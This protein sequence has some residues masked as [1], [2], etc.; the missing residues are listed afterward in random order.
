MEAARSRWLVLLAVAIASM[1]AVEAYDASY[2]KVRTRR[3]VIGLGNMIGSVTGKNIF[4]VFTNY[5]GYGCYCGIGGRGEPLDEV[6]RCCQRHDRCFAV[7]QKGVCSNSGKTVYS[8][9]YKYTAK[10][11]KDEHLHA[12]IVCAPARSYKESHAQGLCSKTMCECD[13][14]VANCFARH[15]HNPKYERYDRKKC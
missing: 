5:N 6:D 8:Q 11:I 2:F 12:D 1:A 14:E 15:K 9:S 7:A 13:R 3:D 4:S 10:D